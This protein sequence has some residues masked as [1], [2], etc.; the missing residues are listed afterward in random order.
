M[1]EQDNIRIAE[2]IFGAM[3]GHD[4]DRVQE[5]YSAD[6]EFR[7]PGTPGPIGRDEGRAYMQAYFGAF[8]DLHW[9][10][11]HKIA[12][13]D[14]VVLNWVGTGTHDGPLSTPGGGSVPATG[15]KATVAGSNTLE[16]AN[17]KVV[18]ST[19]YFDSASLLAQLGLMPGM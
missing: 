11:T 14:F 5:H 19:T 15:K 4:L 8:S 1:S 3:N 6:Y 17:G 7:G 9:Q 18:G 16:F 13:G 12:Q 10:I 2:D